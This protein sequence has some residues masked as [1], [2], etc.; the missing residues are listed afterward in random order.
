M[1][2]YHSD[3]ASQI[4]SRL[5]M[6]EVAE[7]YGFHPNR[8]SFIPCPFHDEQTA[9]CK[10]YQDGFNCFG[11]SAG[12][13]IFEFAKRLFSISFSQAILRL[14]EDFGLGLCGQKP[15]RR[16]LDQWQR[17]QAA[18]A[19]QFAT[20]RAK[21]DRKVEL[22]RYIHRALHEDKPVTWRA[23]KRRAGWMAE[24]EWLDWWFEAHRWL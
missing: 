18:K 7:R 24:I 8:S 13:D 22:H 23:I 4:K 9:S 21:Y 19:K 14:N 6:P 2:T 1:M 5:T 17:E 12:G 3:T 15:D 11:C 16:A 10:I 20:Y